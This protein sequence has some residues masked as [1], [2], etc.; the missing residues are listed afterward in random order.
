MRVLVSLVSHLLEQSVF[1]KNSIS[2]IILLQTSQNQA[3][4]GT[5]YHA[6]RCVCVPLLNVKA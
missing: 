1:A 2:I 6:H 5:G 4:Y 3:A